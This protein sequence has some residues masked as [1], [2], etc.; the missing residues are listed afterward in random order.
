MVAYETN[1]PGDAAE[2]SLAIEW[3]PHFYETAWFVLF[4]GAC[5][6]LLAWGGYRLHVSRLRREFAAVLEER[7]RL[8]RDMHDTLIQGCVGVSA[9][10]E[11]AS[12]AEHVSPHLSHELLDRARGEV[13]AAVDEARLA[14]WNLRHGSQDGV[15]FVEAVSR[16][17]ERI[18]LESQVRVKVDAA[19]PP[20]VLGAELE[21]S[22]LLLIR[23]ALHNAVRHAG[24]ENLSVG[25]RFAR[26]RLEVEILDDGCGFDAQAAADDDG[27]H[28]GLIG[29]RERV[30]SVGGE[31]HLT[32]APGKGTQVRLSVPAAS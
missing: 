11:A 13:R 9:L 20:F 25:L 31:F 32:S 14:V 10:L 7:N 3:Q 12:H 17:A 28:Y 27:R 24:P 16:L 6:T 8:A 21:G 1:A 23:E 2:R 30:E 22:L 15:G 4:C 26:R 18:G 19:G 5:L 29:M